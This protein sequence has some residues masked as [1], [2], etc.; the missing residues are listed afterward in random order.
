MFNRKRIRNKNQGGYNRMIEFFQNL[1]ATELF[2]TGSLGGSIVAA[3]AAVICALINR[4]GTKRVESKSDATIETINNMSTHLMAGEKK[5]SDM[6]GVLADASTKIDTA[7]EAFSKGLADSHQQNLS[8]AAFVLECFNQSNLSDEKKATLQLLFDQMFY[9][10]KAE[11]VN[12]LHADKTGLEADLAKQIELNQAILKE[13]EDT[14]TQLANATA[15]T[16]K[17]RRI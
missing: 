12:K 11:L 1:S 10:N 13:L 2:A 8:I 16:K 14:K 7:L 3:V 9:E 5:N 6:I 17:S 15:T 4:R